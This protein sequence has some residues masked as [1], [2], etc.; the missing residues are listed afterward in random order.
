MEEVWAAAVGGDKG[1]VCGGLQ[2]EIGYDFGV[3]F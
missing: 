2:H 3:V 1:A